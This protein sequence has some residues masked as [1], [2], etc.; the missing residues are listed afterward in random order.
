MKLV[1][2]RG[3]YGGLMCNGCGEE[4]NRSEHATLEALKKEAHAHLRASPACKAKS[5]GFAWTHLGAFDVVT[6]NE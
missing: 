3:D 2:N 1:T 5:E 6:T 4:V